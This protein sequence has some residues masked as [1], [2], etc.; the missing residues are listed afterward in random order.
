MIGKPVSARLSEPGKSQP[1]LSSG[2]GIAGGN[3]SNKRSRSFPAIAILL[4]CIAGS[5]LSGQAAS[6]EPATRAA[7]KSIIAWSYEKANTPQFNVLRE[8]ADKF[9]R[10]QTGYRVEIMPLIY[11]DKNKEAANGNLPCLLNLDGSELAGFAWP[12]YL[13]PIERFVTPQFLNDF[14]PSIVAQGR[15][16]GRL[17]ALGQFDSGVVLWGNR[18]YLRAAGVRIP[19]LASPWSLAEFEEALAKL[20]ALKEVDYPLDLALYVKIHFFYSYVISPML[21]GFGGDLIDR[22]NY[23]TAKGVLD[24]PQSV[25]AMT[26]L[27]SWVRKGW[28]RTESV[29]TERNDFATGKAALSWMGHWGYIPYQKALGKDLVLMPLPDFG[30][31][32][33]TGMGSVVWGIS[34]TCPHPDAT[35]KF[36]AHYLLSPETILRMTNLNGGIPSRRSALARSP[37]YRPG[38]PLILI[39]RQLEVA[40]VPRPP[41]PAFET[42]SKA[43]GEAVSNIVSGADVQSELSKT[44]DLIDRAIAAKQWYPYP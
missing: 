36:L 43:F 11:R 17:Y 14:L 7:P 3:S 44:A 29:S 21:Q 5:A 26:H 13:Q 8:A 24:G 9:N 12:Q 34:S 39:Q 4:G 18:R 33:K 6:A 23:R 31:G 32:I 40:G 25:Q 35:W 22:R 19:T 37:L 16:Q 20:A 15:Y 42:V 28:I 38:G 10:E 2:C 27:Q 41:T 30:H 1:C